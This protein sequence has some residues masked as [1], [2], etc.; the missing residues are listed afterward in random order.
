VNHEVGSTGIT[1]DHDGLSV[2]AS[3]AIGGAGREILNNHD[4]RTGMADD[5]E[6]AGPHAGNDGT[7]DR[8]KKT[9]RRIPQSCEACRRRKLKVPRVFA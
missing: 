4:S 5:Q 8:V 7:P 9:R 3:K 2:T 6:R 1:A